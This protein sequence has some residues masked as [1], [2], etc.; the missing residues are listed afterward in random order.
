MRLFTAVRT[1]FAE[2][3]LAAAVEHGVEQLVV[4]GAGLDTFAYGCHVPPRPILRHDLKVS[5]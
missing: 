3:A 2:D 4:L 5:P 1:R